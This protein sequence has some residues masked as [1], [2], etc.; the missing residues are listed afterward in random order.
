MKVELTYFKE[1]GKYYSGGEY[2]TECEHMFQI[3]CEVRVMVEQ[4]KL[5]ELVDGA[6]GYHVLINVPDHPHNH[7]HLISTRLSDSKA[8]QKM[9]RT[10][11]AKPESGWT[12]QLS[13]A[14]DD[15][16]RFYDMVVADVGHSDKNYVFQCDGLESLLKQKATRIAT[17]EAENKAYDLR[18]ANDAKT[19]AELQAALTD[20]QSQT[21]KEQDDE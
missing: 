17:L 9:F 7:P 15:G 20:Y 19:I 21:R 11:A 3:F 16:F 1:R 18:M 14:L 8:V 12:Y 2:E 4:R 10:L 6:H 13:L 5:P